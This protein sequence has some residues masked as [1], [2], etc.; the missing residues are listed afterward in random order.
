MVPMFCSSV[1]NFVCIYSQILTEID[2]ILKLYFHA[3]NAKGDKE[4]WDH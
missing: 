3:V 2:N 4:N 1:C